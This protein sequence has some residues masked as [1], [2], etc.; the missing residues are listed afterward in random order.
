MEEIIT[1]HISVGGGGEE[2][3][4]LNAAARLDDDAPLARFAVGTVS[5]AI[6]QHAATVVAASYLAKPLIIQQQTP[7]DHALRLDARW[8]LLQRITPAL[9]E[10][11]EG[12]SHAAGATL[13]ICVDWAHAYG[14]TGQQQQQQQQQP[15]VEGGSAGGWRGRLDE[16]CA[17]VLASLGR[18]GRCMFDLSSSLLGDESQLLY[19]IRHCGPATV[20]F[21]HHTFSCRLLVRHETGAAVLAVL[22]DAP[23]DVLS[24][25]R[26]HPP[27]G[28]SLTSEEEG[29]G[30]LRLARRNGGGTLLHA[31]CANPK[32]D[33]GHIRIVHDVLGVSVLLLDDALQSPID[34]LRARTHNRAGWTPLI[35]ELA[36]REHRALAVDPR[37][38]L[39]LVIAFRR[40]MPA[41]VGRRIARFLR[42]AS[43]SASSSGA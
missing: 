30:E 17:E 28:F 21:L 18:T 40:G 39:A 11:G 14:A 34:L 6:A 2:E 5:P 4:Y 8:R 32:A 1:V 22:A 20:R 25:F 41:E 7:H 24:V 31:V 37:H 43:S 15:T 35:R 19:A 10:E 27:R 26:H 36:L 9:F 12:F 33:E 13:R 23:L 38:K 42:V 3:A 16:R 29:G